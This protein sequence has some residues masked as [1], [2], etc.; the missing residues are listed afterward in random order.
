[1]VASRLALHEKISEW[2]NI[3]VLL[4]LFIFAAQTLSS[5]R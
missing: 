2:L 3:Q 5:P 4:L 1:M